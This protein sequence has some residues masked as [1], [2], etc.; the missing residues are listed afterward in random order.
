[1]SI[2]ARGFPRIRQINDIAPI[3]LAIS[4][5]SSNG[6][7]SN[8]AEIGSQI[9][10][11]IDGQVPDTIALG[12]SVDGSQY[13]TNATFIVPGTNDTQDPQSPAV[14]FYTATKDSQTIRGTVDIRAPLPVNTTPPAITNSDP[15]GSDLGDVISVSAGAWNNASSTSRRLFLS[16]GATVEVVAPYTIT[17]ADD[18]KSFTASETAVSSGGTVTVAATGA[19]TVDDFAAPAFTT[20]PVITAARIGAAPSF[21]FPTFTGNPT[22]TLALETLVAGA[23]VGDE[24]YVLV[25]GD[26]GESVALRATLTN[27]VGAPVV[28]TSAAIQVVYNAPTASGSLP[29]LTF[30]TGA[31]ITPVDLT[32]VVSVVGDADLSGLSVALAP[33][34]AALATGLSISTSGILSGTPS[35][36]AVRTIV[37]RFTNSGGFVDR[38]FDLTTQAPAAATLTINSLSY[39]RGAAGVAP[40]LAGTASSSGSVTGPF[41]VFWATRS[42]GTP[43]PKPNIENGTGAA[44]DNGSYSAASLAALSNEPDLDTALLSGAFDVFIRDSSGTPVE[45]DVFSAPGADY[46]PVAPAFAS[47]VVENAATSDVVIT[48]S[49][50]TYDPG[51]NIDPADFVLTGFTVSTATL[52]STT[53][54]TLGVTPAVA[55]GDDLTGDLDYT[56]NYLV[57][58]DEEVMPTFAD[59]DVTNNV[60]AGPTAPAAFVDS[61]WSVATGSGGNELDI[62]LASLPANGGATIS[63]VQYDIDGSN[64]WIS[65]PGYAGTGTYTVAMAAASTSYDI[66]LRAVNSAGA[67]AAGNTESATSGAS[68]GLTFTRVATQLATNPDGINY[69]IAEANVQK[70]AG[71]GVIYVAVAN[72]AGVV[73]TN[74]IVFHGVTL[75][76]VP[77]TDN[78]QDPFQSAIYSG[79]IPASG[80]GDLTVTTSDF[81][82]EAAIHILWVSS[83]PTVGDQVAAGAQ[84]S[85][86]TLDIDTTS[87]GKLFGI[88][89][90]D[91]ASLNFTGV[92]NP[93]TII[94]GGTEQAD[95]LYQDV[96][97]GQTPRP[98]SESGSGTTTASLVALS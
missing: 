51:G 8:Y 20:G 80:S 70:P 93:E 75:T 82:F 41:T 91:A 47:A 15:S 54:I 23:D 97:S 64:T 1:M 31:A 4:G 39:N 33:T 34:S 81:T 28:S 46:D 13:G 29:D 68:A 19:F 58:V 65:L 27:G 32:S 71:G 52:T 17:E 77:N 96:I 25:E 84:G 74:T 9:V 5:L 3:A 48:L 79:V 53:A 44:L 50:A 83:A 2:A 78:R 30:D 26:D 63:N 90:F 60:A 16:D 22:P 7:F 86:I 37:V 85:L 57:G 76:L 87:G 49:K 69:S 24:T 61:N 95:G 72:L 88:A 18:Q 36:E 35:E 67:A 6:Q 14:L 42:T 43:L 94:F 56:G 55:N 73:V 38:A 98:V 92:T 11:T 62:T 89:G 12:T 10:F 40:T 45:S 21:N 66:R 59:Q